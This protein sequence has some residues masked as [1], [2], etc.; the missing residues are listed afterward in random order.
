MNYSVFM[1]VVLHAIRLRV[2]K[3][4]NAYG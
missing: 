4:V 1:F 3:E 2:D